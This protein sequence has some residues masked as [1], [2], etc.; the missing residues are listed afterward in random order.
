MISESARPQLIVMDDFYDKPELVRDLALTAEYV[1]E[2]QFYKGKRSARSFLFDGLKERFEALLGRK[3]T[4]WAE[5]GMNGRFQC[6]VAG[7]PLV[8][9]ADLQTHAAAI[10]LTPDAPPE[11]GTRFWKSKRTGARIC[12]RDSGL[13]N[14]TFNGKLL[15]PTAWEEVDRVGNV[16]NRLALW[17]GH[18]IHSAG[19]YFGTEL[20]NARL[21]HLFF[22][23]CE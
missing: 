5:H 4:K 18:M 13:V 17:N 11:A 16:F 15:D 20:R 6:T 22:F 23:D 19:A 2:S 7:D 10:Y 12:P 9:H 14:L 8:Y 21:V 1:A 3:I